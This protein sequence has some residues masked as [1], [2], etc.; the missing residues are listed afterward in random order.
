MITDMERI[1]IWLRYCR[2]IYSPYNEVYLKEII[3]IYLMAEPQL[4]W[5][6]SIDSFVKKIR[7]SKRVIKYDDK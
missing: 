2:N 7:I 1:E 5:L 6:D 3:H 4:K